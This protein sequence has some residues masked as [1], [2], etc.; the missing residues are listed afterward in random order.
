MQVRLA[1]RGISLEMRIP[2]ELTANSGFRS[3]SHDTDLPTSSL[4]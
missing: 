4:A 3:V 1:R 2:K